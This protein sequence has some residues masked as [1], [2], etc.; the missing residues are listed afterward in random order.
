MIHLTIGPSLVYQVDGLIRQES[1]VDIL[2]AGVDCKLQRLVCIV[3][4]MK[5]LIALLQLFQDLERLC[6]GGLC[7]VDL[8]EATHQT[9]RLREMTVVFLVGRRADKA[10]IP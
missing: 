3:H 6:D 7:D 5:L 8:L 4:P 2:R 1:F 9:F 10:D